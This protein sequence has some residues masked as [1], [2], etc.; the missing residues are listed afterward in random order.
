MR[1]MTV[2][3]SR[4]PGEHGGKPFDPNWGIRKCFP[5]GVASNSLPSDET[6]K[7]FQSMAISALRQIVS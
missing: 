1:V 3:S 7:S 4:F 5:K 2:V 6:P